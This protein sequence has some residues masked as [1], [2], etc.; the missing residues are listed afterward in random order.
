MIQ[1]QTL[2]PTPFSATAEKF[3]ETMFHKLRNWRHCPPG[4]DCLL[5]RES[6]GTMRYFTPN[7]Q[8][9]TRAEAA[10]L[11]K[12]LAQLL[13]DVLSEVDPCAS[14]SIAFDR[15]RRGGCTLHRDGNNPSGRIIVQQ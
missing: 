14:Y 12:Y 8:W 9:G 15:S 6:C 1:I 2:N 5:V 7:A 4:G 3:V 11:P 13:V 10:I